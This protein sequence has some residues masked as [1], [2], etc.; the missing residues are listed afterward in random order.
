MVARLAQCAKTIVIVA[1]RVASTI[2]ICMPTSGF[3]VIVAR[4]VAATSARYVAISV[5]SRE[6][7]ANV[8]VV[9]AT[10]NGNGRAKRASMRLFRLQQHS[11][12]IYC[13]NA[14]SIFLI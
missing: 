14:R 5:R 2:A 12:I 1:A 9:C 13:I 4:V 3:R 7:A 8:W 6:F 11:E 10:T